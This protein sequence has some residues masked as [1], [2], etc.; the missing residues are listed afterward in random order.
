MIPS[1][2]TKELP[3]HD[4][5]SATV[6]MDIKSYIETKLSEIAT[7]RRLC[8]DGSWPSNN[9]IAAILKKCSGLFIIASIIVRF[10]DYPYATPKD[11]LKMI[12]D[13]PNSTIFEGKAGIDVM[14]T[15]ILAACLQNVDPD[16]SGFFDQLRLV[17]GS[18]VLAFK[19]LSRADF[20]KILQMS[21]GRIWN[22]LSRLHSVIIVPESD[23]EPIRIC[24]KSFAD[25]ITEQQRCADSSY[26]INAPAHHLALGALCLELMNTTLTKNICSLP[27]YAMNY[28]IKDLPARREKYIGT[29]LAY[30]CLSWAKHLKSSLGTGDDTTYIV[31]LVN[32]LFEDRFLSWLEVLSIEGAFRVS[33]H[34]FHDVRSWLADV[35]VSVQ[36]QSFGC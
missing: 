35:S 32:Y 22:I 20:A 21:S 9:E 2:R 11:R 17:V 4:V 10:I 3:L 6:D 19:P 31:E 29:S 30:A 36:L 23:M 12:M 13:M 24:H 34:S 33:I 5:D 28:E 8:I 1:L 27:R 14:Y 7:R 25:F 15:Q 16:D 26:F 18:I